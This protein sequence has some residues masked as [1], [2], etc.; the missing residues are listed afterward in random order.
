MGLNLDWN[1]R[2]FNI[3]EITPGSK[4]QSAK[5]LLGAGR[6]HAKKNGLKRRVRR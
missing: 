6:G 1:V 3:L 2:L 5:T 4:Y